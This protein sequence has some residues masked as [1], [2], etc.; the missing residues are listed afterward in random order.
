MR[1]TVFIGRKEVAYQL[2]SRETLLWV[3][4]LPLV[5]FFFIGTVTGGMGGRGAAPDPIVLEAPGD[6]GFL[7]DRLERLLQEQ[8][9]RVIRGG[10]GTTSDVQRRLVLPVGLLDTLRAGGQATVRFVHG[11]EGLTGDYDVM[12]A[13]RATYTL[14]ADMVAAADTGRVPT[15]AALARL[16]SLPRALQLET[17]PAGRRREVPTGF[18]QSVPGI[19]V[20]F[21][22]LVMTTSGA[23]MLVV[24]R[25]QGLLRRLAS[26]PI[27]RREVVV[28]KWGGKLALG[29]VQ[30]GFAMLVGGLLLQVDWG[31]DLAMVLLVMIAYAALA[32]GLGLL[33]G[34]VARTEGQAVAVGVIAANA[35]GALG[36]CWWPIEVAPR[37]MQHLQLFLPTG[38]AMD[39]LHKLMSYQAGA[40]SAVPHVVGMTAATAVLLAA[41]SRLFRYQ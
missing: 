21:V 10:P 26:T 31:P 36:G 6:A 19:M 5:F 17:A 30:V 1:G 35:L 20:M 22:L 38:W 2:R 23:V 24:E 16:D 9:F 4:V 39:A 18:Q 32:A 7:V 15:P 41:S 34:I 40:A 33:L 37:W 29:L 28:G 27:R 12:R 3:F 13:G 14:L 8:D 11:S 25:R